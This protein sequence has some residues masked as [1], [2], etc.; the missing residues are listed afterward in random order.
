ML[1]RELNVV[2]PFQLSG[3]ELIPNC[4][5]IKSRGVYIFSIKIRGGYLIEYVGIVTAKDRNFSMRIREHKNNNFYG[6]EKIYEYNKF[7]K[8]KK[9]AIWEGSY[10]KNKEPKS[11]MANF[12]SIINCLEPII[13]KGLTH[14]I[15]F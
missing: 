2:G 9:I 14:V 6:Y 3:N 1:E 11:K 5:E 13:I 15:F 7:I 4:P 10:G 8:G 12:D